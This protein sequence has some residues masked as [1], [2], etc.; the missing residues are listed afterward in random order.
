MLRCGTPRKAG[1]S[2]I[3][4]LPAQQ[5]NLFVGWAHTADIRRKLLRANPIYAAG[6]DK[7]MGMAAAARQDYGLGTKRAGLT[8]KRYIIYPSGGHGELNPFL[9]EQLLADRLSSL[10]RPGGK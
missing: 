5:D 1:S 10:E 8:G 7:A 4:I 9:E 3:F 2:G 6:Y